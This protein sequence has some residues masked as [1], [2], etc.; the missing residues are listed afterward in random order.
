MSTGGDPEFGSGAYYGGGERSPGDIGQPIGLPGLGGVFGMG[1]PGSMGGMGP[2]G[3]FGVWPSC[4]CSSCV[5]VLA[6][7]L[8][9]FGGCLRMLG[10]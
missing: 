1:R 6:V 4:G 7:F 5:I 3:P 10:Q 8:L 2:A 9:V